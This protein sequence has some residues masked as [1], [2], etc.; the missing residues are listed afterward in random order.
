MEYACTP[1]MTSLPHPEDV[2]PTTA[3]AI[4]LRRVSQLFG[5]FVALR[6]VSLDLPE[7]SSV[8][9][10]GPNGAGKSTLLRILAGLASPAYGDVRIWGEP[11]S[12]L[13]GRIAYMS[14]STMLYDELTGQ[15]NLEYLLGLQR[16]ALPPA[17]RT[18][19]VAEGL[20]AV[21][22]DPANTRRLGEY[23]QGM[24]QRASLARV[25]LAEPDLL[26]L[27][28]PF[29]NLDVGSAHAM[30]VRLQAYLSEKS[31]EQSGRALPRTLLFTTHQAALAQPLAKMTLL[32]EAGKL[33]SVSS[34]ILPSSSTGEIQPVQLR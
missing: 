21:G 31:A 4:S 28:E 6:E 7:G 26:L 22:L 2:R 3:L 30:I 19:R 25:L 1:A 32:L 20:R 15:E 17:D 5:S 18:R 8:M 24:R 33:V 23:S 9:L 29:S 11:P 16:P 27:D 12:H 34:D 14:H 13:R 10:L